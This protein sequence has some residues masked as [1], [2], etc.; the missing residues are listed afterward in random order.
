MNLRSSTLV[1]LE[2]RRRFKTK[3]GPL[4]LDLDSEVLAQILDL[5][6]DSGSRSSSWAHGRP[7]SRGGRRGGGR[8]GGGKRGRGRGNDSGGGGSGQ[9]IVFL[10][11]SV[12]DIALPAFSTPDKHTLLPS[13]VR[14]TIEERSN[15]Y[16]TKVQEYLEETTSVS[17]YDPELVESGS[18]FLFHGMR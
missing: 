5:D 18:V 9:D 16:S 13:T 14:H 7:S 10:K 2:D 1:M 12:V 8:R 17:L 4:L 3:S 11:V 6:L 15:L